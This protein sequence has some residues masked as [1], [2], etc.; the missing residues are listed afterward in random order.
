MK[1]IAKE[2]IELNMALIEKRKLLLGIIGYYT[3]L[4]EPQLPGQQVIE[5]YHHLWRVEQS[6]RMSKFDLEASQFIIKRRMLSAP[7]C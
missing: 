4:S 2:K 6:F 7:M 1:R 5:R 3:D